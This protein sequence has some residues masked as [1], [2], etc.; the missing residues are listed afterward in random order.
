[1][2]AFVAGMLL[3]IAALLAWFGWVLHA[4][5]QRYGLAFLALAAATCMLAGAIL[6]GR[7]RRGGKADPGPPSIRS[8]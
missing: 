8:E 2:R 3:V 4:T 5:G 1:M 6:L 7:G